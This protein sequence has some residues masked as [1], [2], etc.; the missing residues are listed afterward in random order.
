MWIFWRTTSYFTSKTEH[1]R[2]YQLSQVVQKYRS[3]IR[4]YFPTITPCNVRALMESTISAHDCDSKDTSINTSHMWWIYIESLTSC[5]Q[6]NT[7]PSGIAQTLTEKHERT[8]I[9][10]VLSFLVYHHHH[11]T[12]IVAYCYYKRMDPKTSCTYRIRA[13][14]TRL[15]GAYT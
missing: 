9:C 4:H 8:T 15:V 2:I 6:P 11:V 5:K 3:L 12:R 1:E 7:L 10:S 13:Q 14:S